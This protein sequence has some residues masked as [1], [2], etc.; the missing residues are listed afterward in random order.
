VASGEEPGK[1]RGFLGDRNVG[2]ATWPSPRPSPGGH[3]PKNIHVPPTWFTSWS[4]G[5]SIC[6]KLTW[7]PGAQHPNQLGPRVPKLIWVLSTWIPGVIL[8]FDHH[9]PTRCSVRWG[10]E[11]QITPG[12]LK[13]RLLN[14]DSTHSESYSTLKAALCKYIVHEIHIYRFD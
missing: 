8:Y 3:I 5:E 11:C 12:A 2:E 9:L 4:A 13:I 7:N 10:S 14:F 6:L 1:K